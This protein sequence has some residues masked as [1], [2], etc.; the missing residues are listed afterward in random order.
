MNTIVKFCKMGG[1]AGL[2]DANKEIPG[3][4]FFNIV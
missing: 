1:N 4:F 2:S 3:R